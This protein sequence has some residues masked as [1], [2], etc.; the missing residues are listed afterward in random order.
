MSKRAHVC[1][2]VV[3]GE[4]CEGPVTGTLARKTSAE[5]GAVLCGGHAHARKV[6]IDAAEDEKIAQAYRDRVA[7]RKEA[8]AVASF[9]ERG[10]YLIENNRLE[11][12]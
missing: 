2:V 10:P 5:Y 11:A 9:N 8:E 6:A 7:K 12:P 1:S 4:R 3:N